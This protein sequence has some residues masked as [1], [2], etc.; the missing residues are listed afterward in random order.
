MKLENISKQIS[1]WFDGS[2][3]HSNIVISSRIRLARNIAGY[4]FLPRLKPDRQAEILEKLKT[5]ILSVNVGEEVFFID[6][7]ESSTLEQDLMVE[8]HLISHRHARGK[9][10]RGAVIAG[11]ESFTAMI[12]EEDHL[13]I[14]VLGGGSQ[15]SNCYEKINKIDDQIEE[16]INY[17]FSPKLG[18]LTACPTN[19]GTG[20]R[21]SASQ[22]VSR[23]ITWSM[24]ANWS[25]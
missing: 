6:V 15:L 16:Q 7:A 14:Q 24:R 21:V 13:R 17:A 25:T 4:E 20:I 5:A 1:K 18:Y 10:P 12:N 22:V 23:S 19:L 11:A 8:R 9:G 3:P 2:G